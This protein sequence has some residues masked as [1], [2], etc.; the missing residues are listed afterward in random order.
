MIHD[1]MC[2]AREFTIQGL[3]VKVEGFGNM[4]QG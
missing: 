2:R 1:A 4:D 3:Q